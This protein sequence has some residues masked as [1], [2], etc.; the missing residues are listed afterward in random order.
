MTSVSSRIWTSVAV[1]ISYDDNNYTMGSS[2]TFLR[3]YTLLGYQFLHLIKWNIIFQTIIYIYIYI[4]ILTK[5][6]SWY[7]SFYVTS[8]TL[9]RHLNLNLEYDP[10]SNKSWQSTKPEFLCVDTTLK[11]LKKRLNVYGVWLSAMMN[12]PVRPIIN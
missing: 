3:L 10:Y 9:N 1:S 4:Y 7:I 12:N 6:V 11:I 5:S 2:K 8:G